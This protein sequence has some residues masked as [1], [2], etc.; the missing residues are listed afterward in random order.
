MEE[1]SG[2]GH[3]RNT[4]SY[5]QQQIRVPR[6]RALRAALFTRRGLVLSIRVQ[7]DGPFLA[8]ADTDPPRRRRPRWRSQEEEWKWPQ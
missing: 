2:E 5:Y 6:F 4:F 3:T 1:V 8:S 7:A